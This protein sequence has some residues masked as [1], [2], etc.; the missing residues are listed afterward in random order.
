MIPQIESAV[1]GTNRLVKDRSRKSGS[2][3]EHSLTKF[4]PGVVGP[5]VVLC[6]ALIFL[7]PN[8]FDL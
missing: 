7:A 1:A 8:D 4:A 2:I 5:Y 6:N 3:Q